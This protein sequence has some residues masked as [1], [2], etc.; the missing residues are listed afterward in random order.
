V[1]GTDTARRLVYALSFPVSGRKVVAAGQ[2]VPL[3][4]LPMAVLALMLVALGSV[5]AVPPGRGAAV[6]LS[7]LGC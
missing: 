5:Q 4:M 7:G 2:L 6:V 3:A 1:E